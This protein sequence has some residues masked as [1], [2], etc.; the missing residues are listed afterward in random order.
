MTYNNK[1]WALLYFILESDNMLDQ[2]YEIYKLCIQSIAKHLDVQVY[3]YTIPG[4]LNGISFS[5][6][7]MTVAKIKIIELPLW[8]WDKTSKILLIRKHID[9]QQNIIYVRQKYFIGDFNESHLTKNFYS[10]FHEDGMD[11]SVM[12][13][14]S[15]PLIQQ[16]IANA[17]NSCHDSTDLEPGDFNSIQFN[18]NNSLYHS[19]QKLKIP[20]GYIHDIIPENKLK[21][22]KNNIQN[23]NLLTESTIDPDYDHESES[24]LFNYLISTKNSY[25]YYPYL[26]FSKITSQIPKNLYPTQKTNSTEFT[27]NIVC[28][29]PPYLNSNG[30]VPQNHIN[31][32]E[33]VCSG[34]DIN[35]GIFIEKIYDDKMILIPKIVHYVCLESPNDEIIA[36]WRKILKQP[37]K[38]ICWDYLTTYNEIIIGSKWHTIFDIATLELRKI[39]VFLPS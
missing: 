31:I 25:I 28:H 29:L 5:Q 33:L 12:I 24:M 30:F 34:D 2:E 32:K 14:Q 36:S 6:E 37:W 20:I 21:C 10:L 7:L 22:F 18:L 38:F 19:C 26:Y 39:I 3:I 16:M 27:N 11:S 4:L 9:E 17:Y 13:I 8:F 1:N 35:K 15:T 23:Y